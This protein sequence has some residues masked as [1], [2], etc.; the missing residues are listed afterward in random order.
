MFTLY[1]LY[2]LYRTDIDLVLLKKEFFKSAAFD[3]IPAK[4]IE[5]RL[6]EINA[7]SDSESLKTSWQQYQQQYD[8]A[9][10]ISYTT[11]LE[12][13]LDLMKEIEN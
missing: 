2:I 3:H 6:T 7:L 4:P 10:S 8:Y 9:Q 5:N 11:A 13:L 1:S 12:A